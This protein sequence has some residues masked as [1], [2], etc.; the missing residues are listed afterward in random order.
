MNNSRNIVRIVCLI[1]AALFVIPM[2][3]AAI[4]SLTGCS[5]FSGDADSPHPTVPPP[6][7]VVFNGIGEFRDFAVLTEKAAPQA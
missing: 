6:E 2:L 7:Q 3:I 4:M 5:A 1:L